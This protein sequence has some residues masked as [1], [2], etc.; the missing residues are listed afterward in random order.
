MVFGPLLPNEDI[1][2][3]APRKYTHNSE[4]RDKLLAPNGTA[5]QFRGPSDNAY[6]RQKHQNTLN[7]TWSQSHRKAFE[8][9]EHEWLLAKRQLENIDKLF[10]FALVSRVSSLISTLGI[11]AK[12]APVIRPL[13]R[14]VIAGSNQC[15]IRH[16]SKINPGAQQH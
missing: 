5:V 6:V 4:K 2:T 7:E 11:L 15:Q 9:F 1:S 12:E 13:D 16:R 10:F 8:S 14:R 3:G